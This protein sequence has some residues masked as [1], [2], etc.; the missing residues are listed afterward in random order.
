MKKTRKEKETQKRKRDARSD[1]KLRERDERNAEGRKEERDARGDRNA[2]EERETREK[3]EKRE[4]KRDAKKKEKR[5]ACTYIF[6]CRALLS[7]LRRALNI[8]TVVFSHRALCTHAQIGR[9]CLINYLLII[10][11]IAKG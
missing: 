8:I 2:R 1:I 6:F 11:K 10:T 3:D 9:S 7:L 4:K 5:A